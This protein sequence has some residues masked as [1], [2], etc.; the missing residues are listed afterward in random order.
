MTLEERK[1]KAA[2]DI[3]SLTNLYVEEIMQKTAELERSGKLG[4][5]LDS[6]SEDFAPVHQKYNACF[7]DVL[8]KYDL[9][10][11]TKLKLW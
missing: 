6:N 10:P 9:P 5:G 4:R 11:D 7:L 8:F 3:L 2:K 1:T